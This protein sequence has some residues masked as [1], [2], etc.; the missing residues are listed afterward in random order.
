[1]YW[2]HLIFVLM[3]QRFISDLVALLFYIFPHDWDDTAELLRFHLA[4]NK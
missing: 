2:I 3:I 1:M 4:F